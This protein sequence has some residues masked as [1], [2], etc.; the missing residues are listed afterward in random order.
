MNINSGPVRRSTTIFVFG[1]GRKQK[2]C[3]TSPFLVISQV[4]GHSF[5]SHLV[6]RL[7]ASSPSMTG[8]VLLGAAKRFPEGGAGWNHGRVP[9][10]IS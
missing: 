2:L 1:R 8:L 3:E 7:A 5:G 10:Q 4:V 6:L 9:A